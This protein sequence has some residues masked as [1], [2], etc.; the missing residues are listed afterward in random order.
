[1]VKWTQADKLQ[2]MFEDI[3]KSMHTL[4]NPPKMLRNSNGEFVVFYSFIIDNG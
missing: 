4:P 3:L 1:M 2:N